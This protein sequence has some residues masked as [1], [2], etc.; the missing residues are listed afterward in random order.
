MTRYL[1]YGGK[2]G[3]GKT[4]CAAATA[5]GLARDGQETLVVSTDPA[6]SLSDSFERDVGAEPTRLADHLWAVEIDPEARMD[7]YED[8]FATLFD[9]FADVG[10]RVEDEQI[11]D[12]FAA[13]LAPG[14]DEVAALDTLVEYAASDRWDVVVLDTAPTGHTLRLLDMPSVVGATARTAMS[15]RSQV[16][17]IADS[18]KRMVLG[19]AYY[20]TS[21]EAETQDRFADLQERM[22]RVAAIL[23]DPDRTEFR[24]VL[25]PERMALAETERLVEQ[26]DAFEIPVDGLVVNKVVVDPAPDCQ[27][28]QARHESQQAII[29]ETRERFPDHEVS[30]LPER[31]TDVRGMAALGDV[32]DWLAD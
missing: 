10:V 14:S 6:H 4:T 31:E 13:G 2:G 7:E 25:V 18:T 30:V 21:R 22:E 28:C 3:V 15:I 12:V 17:R 8:L 26:L 9:E 19:P 16:R 20:M 5:V 23:R 32:A 27:R 29:A 1:L 11:E 24:V